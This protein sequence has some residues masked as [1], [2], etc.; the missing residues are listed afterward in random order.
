MTTGA[1]LN[2]SK[3][4]ADPRWSLQAD[5]DT[6]TLQFAG[7]WSAVNAVPA[8]NVMA[9]ELESLAPGAKRLVLLMADATRWDSLLPARLLQCMHWADD[10]GL[11]TDYRALPG[12]LVE[13][14]RIATAVERHTPTIAP[15]EGLASQFARKLRNM[16]GSAGAFCAF[17]GGAA[18][19][20]GALLR[21]RSN[22][23]LRDVLYFIDQAGPKAL[24]I[25]TLISVL[26]GMILAYMG[27]LQLRQ[28]G[29]QVYV[30]NLVGIGMVREMAALM[31]AI[32]MAGRTGAAYAAQLGTMQTNEEIDALETLGL[33]PMEFLVT[34]RM[35]AL[36]LIMPLLCI[37]SDCVGILGGAMVATGMDVSPLQYL[38]QIQGS[39]SW[40]DICAGL[41][42]SIVFGVLIAI[43]GCQAGLQ[44]GRSSAAVGE[45]T[46]TAVVKAI[47]YIII[48]DSALNIVYDKV[49]L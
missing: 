1:V 42:K 38:N 45:A 26:V 48:A 36:T 21:G 19:A 34:P 47:V 13:L 16:A 39:I 10:A 40:H 18:M 17:I 4:N 12:E 33:S 35:L 15:A 43:A 20:F 37:Y 22:T 41:L 7:N 6:L 27:A 14:L 2:T 25:V 32:I 49:G 8:F 3:L 28:F 24:G 5:H 9:L 11:T 31:T 44:C 46:T 30:A 23:R 29:A